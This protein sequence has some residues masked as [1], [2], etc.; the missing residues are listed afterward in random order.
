MYLIYL[1]KA[2]HVSPKSSDWV[3]CN[4]DINGKFTVDEM[5]NFAPQVSDMLEGGIP[6]LIY[7]GDVDFICNYLGNKAWTLSLDWKYRDEFNLAE[8]HEWGKALGLARTS[9]GLT[10][11]QVYDAGHMVPTDQPKVALEMITR[12]ISGGIF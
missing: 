6:V 3:T 10:F 12:F 8:D 1:A 9:N 2:L 11:L 4:D 7:A 5:Q